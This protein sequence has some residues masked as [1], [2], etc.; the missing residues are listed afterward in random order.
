MKTQ[1]NTNL[2]IIEEKTEW[3]R[4]YADQTLYFK[5]LLAHQLHFDLGKW[6]K[7]LDHYSSAYETKLKITGT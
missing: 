5:C 7:N 6:L 1:T 4:L 2:I 3:N